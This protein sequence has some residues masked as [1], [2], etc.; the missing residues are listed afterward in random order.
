MRRPEADVESKLCRR[1]RVAKPNEGVVTM[2]F[3]HIQDTG[4]KRAK[5]EIQRPVLT[6][7]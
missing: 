4:E 3:K 5:G 6:Y 2:S 7:T 1:D